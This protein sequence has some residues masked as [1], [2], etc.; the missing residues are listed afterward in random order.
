MNASS[1][2]KK[3]TLKVLPS[4]ASQPMS[5]KACDLQPAPV[6]ANLVTVTAR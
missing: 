3:A 4:D 6:L 5:L 2:T 1:T